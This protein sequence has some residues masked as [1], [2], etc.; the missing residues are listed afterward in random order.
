MSVARVRRGGLRC[1]AA[2]LLLFTCLAGPASAFELFGIKFFEGKKAD[3]S[4]DVIGD[5]QNYTLD[6]AVSGG[7]DA[8]TTRLQ[9]ASTLRNDQEKPASGAAGLLAKARGDYNRLLAALYAEGRY[10]GTI[11]IEVDGRQA[12]DLPPDTALPNPVAVRVAVDPGPLFRFGKTEIVDQAPPATDRR[13][14]VKLPRDEGFAPGEPARSGVVLQSEKL[15]VEAW[16]QQGHAKAEIAERRVEAAHDRDLLDATLVVK[17]GRKAYYGPVTVQGTDHIDPQFL[18]WMTG[19]EIGQEY[20]PDDIEQ[21]NK[22]LGRLD[23]FRSMRFQEADAIG[24]EGS[25]PISLV[26]QERPLHRFGVGGSYST[27]DGAGFETYWLHRNLFGQAERLRLEAKVG[28]IGNSF[29]PLDFSYRAGATFTKPGIYTPDTDLIASL[30][31]DREV[32]EPYTRTSIIADLGFTQLL[33]EELSVRASVNGGASKFEDDTYG[34]RDFTNIGVVGGVTFDTRDSKTDP[35]EGFFAEALIEPFYEF[36]YGNAAIRGTLEGR[37]Y[38]GLGAEDN[39]VLAGRLKVGSITGSPIEET[40]PDKLFFAGG[41][42]SVR[43]YAYRNIGV[44][45]AAGDV[46]GGRS[47][48]EA[49]GEVRAKVTSSIGVVGFLDAGY[50][51]ADSAPKFS[52]DL[53]LGAGAGLRYLTGLGSIRLDVAVPLNP[54]DNDPTVAFYV[55]IGQAF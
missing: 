8:L 22:R 25:L 20:D 55:G 51:G 28:G 27:L 4:Q 40:A 21:A 47:L 24:Q 35:T 5:P 13:D 12:S 34:K 7:D 39:V 23:V 31:G 36:S 38:Y 19:L 26:V 18:A 49:S 48:V 50:V 11:S 37:A 45:T 9:G 52:E 33:S 16:R 1:T 44:E 3:D 43:G 53:R 41:G 42:G 15:A 2:S 32:L 54:R 30:I 10:G 29:D 46:V 17:P 6:F 14:R